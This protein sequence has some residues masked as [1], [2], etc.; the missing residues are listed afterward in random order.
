[1]STE[2]TNSTRGVAS[3]GPGAARGRG[4]QLL[5]ERLRRRERRPAPHRRADRSGDLPVTPAQRRLWALDRMR[6]GGTEYLVPLALR[7][8]GD[9]G[10][11][12]LAD[13]V[14]GLV[15]RH[16]VLRTRYVVDASD[17]VVARIDEPAPVPLPTTDL[18]EA[19]D[20]ARAV[21]QVLREETL[22]PIDLAVGPILRAR[23]LRLG[24]EEHVLVLVMHHIA[25]D[26]WSAT[27]L[28]SEL[29]ELA[30][31]REPAMPD[32]Q[33]VD[34]AAGATD[35]ATSGLAFWTGELAGMPALVLPTDHP[36]PAAWR[37][38]GATVAFQLPAGTAERV[39]RLASETRGTPF[40]VY[41]AA[42][43]A[44]LYRYTGQEDFGVATPVAGRTAP[45][46]QDLVGLFVN[47][48]VLRADLAGS[49]TFARLV[50]R[51]RRVALDAYEHQDVGFE[52]VVDALVP[53]RD[54]SGHPLTGVNLTLQN[55]EPP[56]FAAGAVRGEMLPVE[57]HQA[58]F[59][60]GWTLEERA[61]GS[62][63]GEVTFPHSL[64][65]ESTVRAMTGHFTRLV[66]SALDDPHRRVADLEMLSRAESDAATSGPAGAAASAPA[67]PE[68]FAQRVRAHGDAP[69]VTGIAAGGERRTLTYAELD[70]R[71]NRLANTLCERGARR[72]ELVALCLPRGVDLVI[73]VLAVLKAGAAYLPIEPAHPAERTG[74]LLADA[75]PC[76]LVTDRAGAVALSGVDG[77]AEVLV[78][79][80]ECDQADV[81]AATSDPPDVP[82]HPD[83]LAYV[84][85]TS[86]ST[87]RPKGVEVTHANVVRLLTATEDDY[88]FGP[89]DV[90]ACVHSYAFDVSVWEIWGAL[91]HGGRLVMVPH[92][93][94]RSPWELATVLADEGVTVLNQ[95]P[96]AF[97]NLVELTGE[98]VL[99]R[100]RVR[101]VV[102]AG[103]KLDVAMLE[104]WWNRYGPDRTR[105]VNMYG[106]TET[107]VHVTVRTVTPADLSG[108]RSPIGRPMRDLTLHVLDARMGPVPIGVTGE[109][110][111][112][113]PGVTRG[114]LARPA[115]TAD[116]FRP[117]PHGPPGARLYRSGDLARVR[118]DGDL[119]FLGR[120]DNQVKIRG[121]RIEL[122]EI[123]ARLADH[124]DVG[125]AVVTTREGAGGH[126]ELV[127]HAVVRGG[128]P[129]ADELRGYLG[130]RLPSYMVPG[131]IA[132]VGSLP[133]TSNGK[134]DR[135]ALPEPDE[136][137]GAAVHVAPRTG[138]ER[139]LTE[140]WGE[141]LGRETV[142]VHDNFFTA[143][144]DSIRAVRLVGRLRRAGLGYSVEDLFRYQTI[145]ELTAARPD[146]SEAGPRAGTAPFSLLG[147]ADRAALPDRLDDAYPMTRVQAGMVFEMLADPGLGRYH[148]VTSYLIRDA[149]PLDAVALRTAVAELVAAY[150]ILRT[151]FDL[152]GFSGP[153]QLVHRE[154]DAPV[155]VEDLPAGSDA[156]E[157]MA[158]F[159]S[160]ERARLFD[161]GS[162]P[163]VRFHG[164]RTS[165]GWYL[166][167]TECH[168]VLDGWSHNSLVTE[169][170]ARYRAVRDRTPYV[171]EPVP[172]ARFA[173]YVALEQT[174]L[175][176]GID[177]AF[178]AEHLDGVS[179]LTVPAAWA[180]PDGPGQY[181][182]RVPYAP[183]ERGLRE[184]ARRAGAS[185]KSVLLAA[186]V[187]VWRMVAGGD[188]F[189]SGLVGHGRPEVDGGDR[190]RGMFLNTIPVVAPATRGSWCDLVRDVFAEEVTTWAH[191]RYPMPQLQHE[192]GGE[193]MIDVAFNYLDFHVLDRDAVDTD[194]STDVGFTEFPFCALTEA[195]DLV[196]VTY[197]EHVGRRHGELLA[198]MY[199]R[200]FELMAGNPDANC[201]A[202]LLP[203]AERERLA[204][205]GV[206]ITERDGPSRGV[207]EVV[208]EHVLTRP[209]AVAVAAADG[210]L[211]YRE[212]HQ[213]AGAWTSHLRGLGV[214]PGDLVGVHLPR[215]RELVAAAL[216]IVGLGAAY[217]PV[218]PQNPAER[219]S[220][221][222]RRAGVRVVAGDPVGAGDPFTVL[223]P[224]RV[225]DVDEHH[226]PHA[227]HPEELV[228]VVHTSGSSG[229]PKGI[230]LRQQALADRVEALTADLGL[231][232]D[233]VLVAVMPT[234]SDVWQMD[235][236][237]ALGC[238]ARLVLAGEADARDPVSLSHLLRSSGATVML[239]T[240][241]TWRLLDGTGWTP[242]PGF[243]RIS[244]G[245]LIGPELTSRMAATDVGVWDMYGP[246]EATGYCFNNTYRAGAEPGW[247]PATHT[248]CY[249]LGPDLEP[250]ADGVPGQV[251]AGG[252][253]L[254]RGYL[255]QPATTAAA[256]LPDPFA[257]RPG[258][259]MYATGDMG[260]RGPDGRIEIL[261]RRDH[262]LKIRGFRVEVGEVEAT[263]LRHPDVTD[264]VVHP[265]P[266]PGGTRR[267]AGY[268]VAEA[269]QPTVHELV[270]FLRERLPQYMVPTFLR[271]MDALPMLA[272][273]KVD[274]SALPVPDAAQPAAD[275]EYAEPRGRRECAIAAVWAEVLEVG[276]VGRHDDFYALG[277]SS[278]LAMR[279][280]ALLSAR[281]GIDLGFRD[282]LVHR[283]VAATATETA[284]SSSLVRLADG[285]TGSPLFCV[286]PGGGSAHWYRALADQCA[287]RRPVAAFE[288]PGL[289]GDAPA[290]ASLASVAEAYVDDLL[291]EYPS[292]PHHLLGWCGS[293]GIA[294]EMARR[295]GKLGH[296]PHLVLID[297]IEYPATG[298]NPLE[299]NVRVLRRAEHLLAG[300]SGSAP[301]AE[302]DAARAELLA[303][304]RTMVDD[305]DTVFTGDDL[306]AELAHGWARRLRSWREMAELR[307]TYHFE[308][309]PEHVD[310]L[311]CQEMADGGY[312]E[313]LGEPIES[314]VERWRALAGGG[315]GHRSIPGDHTTALFPPHVARLVAVLDELTEQFHRREAPWPPHGT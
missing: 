216:G 193:R 168:A 280:I 147:A 138:T 19:P 229:Q 254:A 126:R 301:G 236:F 113:G 75:S 108:E 109:I 241:T 151:S 103:E 148:N 247:V 87:G 67:L 312:A 14:T 66:G 142:G 96:S 205:T 24:A 273:G 309:I 129:S 277:G 128:G 149:A 63:A 117:D 278:L 208:G 174:S 120:A 51:A 76:L 224:I 78:L 164:H 38:D 212:L 105:M 112:G 1:M 102:F 110:H 92:E 43:W 227:G 243:R 182:L 306:D 11:I 211:T 69:A 202:P 153:T 155:A 22:R 123:E 291:A 20:P 64:W 197:S 189:H 4:A 10:S 73:G 157:R 238:G 121:H 232:H 188:R 72:G 82:V 37:A 104:P 40:M 7:L 176:D 274:R 111:V 209:N 250:V 266:G 162:A 140:A 304:L 285:G 57:A 65:D 183:H 135:S 53:H 170:I 270:R 187:A 305:G 194:G 215:E 260:R 79:D 152:A 283:T 59:D 287:G 54:L 228:C 226:V 100:L 77:P 186:H 217:V 252:D 95:T 225:V 204:T 81:A 42:C 119:G 83:D 302:R 27:L 101:V 70:A 294:W 62:V 220:A 21:A 118:P 6:P 279:I 30:R 47:T 231:G 97:G 12:D 293:S 5:A 23:L 161:L 284:T 288:W 141:V 185:L 311:V 61:D 275:V 116:R 52:R 296:R 255:G 131:W 28:V 34:V 244:G 173:D 137:A 60:L 240:A 13:A 308:P 88:R 256:F 41:L 261:G 223:S 159:R 267:L 221:I 207:H 234:M 158:A 248:P 89:D 136:D 310:V 156:E 196:L 94:T 307:L 190:L 39:A 56:R 55:N 246:G 160:A 289:N 145:A 199:G 298:T 181:A 18:A 297:P 269:P 218:E 125:A 219:N 163:L 177:R 180:D 191:R 44:L 146:A 154:V 290:P 93:T 49:P 90:W 271:I 214:R 134:V 213:R 165:G 169:L 235:V 259:R 299:G 3:A 29:A 122:G 178:W 107:T 276:R 46:V 2:Y 257:G 98:P 265:V 26:G 251:H 91:L 245:E 172:E 313:I 286:H 295:L 171:A 86:G 303:V 253:G 203:A 237:L 16:E 249:L 184:L 144:G 167:L 68:R 36:R 222:L 84:I 9:L 85:Y 281:H 268:V 25:V 239:A 35:P 130:E 8:T 115:L 200:A 242:P 314:Y 50:E 74:L 192:S 80:S 300:M 114:Y 127:A 179:R 206:R 32:L 201:R 17:E 48:V 258:A 33:Y 143:G 292:G 282:F 166:T 106:I 210:T 230:M 133:L 132:V 71:A 263:L 150:E 175:T 124:P 45:E 233:D 315:F 195:G 139:A 198:A 58:K 264:A 262:Q 31:G 15:R 99:D 272:S